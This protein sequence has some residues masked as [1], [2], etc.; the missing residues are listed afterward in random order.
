MIASTMEAFVNE[1][2]EPFRHAIIE[3]ME[4]TIPLERENAATGLRERWDVFVSNIR[5]NDKGKLIGDAMAVDEYAIEEPVV[6][7]V[8]VPENIELVPGKQVLAHEDEATE[9]KPLISKKMALAIG[10]ATLAT[11]VGVGVTYLARRRHS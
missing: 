3:D 5:R 6:G 4:L 1:S 7:E 9:H 8:E 10:G 2:E 11:A